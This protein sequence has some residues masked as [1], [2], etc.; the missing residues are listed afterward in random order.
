MNHR[1]RPIIS[2]WW[3]DERARGYCGKANEDENV[4]GRISSPGPDFAPVT[5]RCC[6]WR[7]TWNDLRAHH[8]HRDEWWRLFFLRQNRAE[9]ER[10]GA[11]LPGRIAAPVRGHGTAC[12]QSKS[13]GAEAVPDSTGCAK[14]FRHRA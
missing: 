13:P 6:A 2:P 14:C 12:G 11:N 4:E 1:P 7:R 8:R 3:A 9:I 10:R 5:R